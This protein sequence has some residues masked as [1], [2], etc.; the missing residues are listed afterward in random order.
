MIRSWV[1]ALLGWK[2]AKRN[3][4]TFYHTPV[5][6]I[7]A[8]LSDFLYVEINRSFEASVLD[9]ARTLTGVFLSIELTPSEAGFMLNRSNEYLSRAQA[10]INS[11]KYLEE[12]L[13][14]TALSRHLTDTMAVSSSEKDVAAWIGNF[15]KAIADADL[16]LISRG[17]EYLQ[18]LIV[19]EAK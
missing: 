12:A 6:S 1:P 13:T 2:D 14:V 17:L 15:R 18:K 9:A 19:E 5:L 10:Y 16:E 8:S 3:I 4:G 11:P 7:K